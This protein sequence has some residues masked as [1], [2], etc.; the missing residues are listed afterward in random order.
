MCCRSARFSSRM[1]CNARY[2]FTSESIVWLAASIPRSGT[3]MTVAMGRPITMRDSWRD[4]GRRSSATTRKRSSRRTARLPPAIDCNEIM[5]HGRA[6]A[7]PRAA[8]LGHHT[9]FAQQIEFVEDLPDAQHHGG[10]GVVHRNDRQARLL[11]QARV[12][13]PEHGPPAR[14]HDPDRKSTRLNSSHGYISYAV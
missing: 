1:C 4:S 14:Q 5:S 8:V 13:P 3:A 9:H 6:A 2:R 12:H 10:E 11:P 7:L